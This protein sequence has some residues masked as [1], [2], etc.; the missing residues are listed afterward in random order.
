MRR[1]KEKEWCERKFGGE[2]NDNGG[3]DIKYIT[4]PKHLIKSINNNRIFLFE[5]LHFSSSTLTFFKIPGL[6]LIILGVTLFPKKKNSGIRFRKQSVF[7]K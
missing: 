1:E 4:P 2:A 7:T 5:L 3:K 6:T